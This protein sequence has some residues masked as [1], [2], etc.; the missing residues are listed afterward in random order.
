MMP[1][2]G[3]NLNIRMY[4][5]TPILNVCCGSRSFEEIKQ[6]SQGI[7]VSANNVSCKYH[8]MSVLEHVVCDASHQP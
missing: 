6:M 8:I 2:I 4:K 7:Y 3:I 1:H 5:K